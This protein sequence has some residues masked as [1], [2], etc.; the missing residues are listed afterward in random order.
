MLSVWAAVMALPF[1]PQ[2]INR[3][4]QSNNFPFLC[5]RGAEKE[6]GSVADTR[7]WIFVPGALFSMPGCP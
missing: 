4:F 5:H 2:A 6:P 7:L 3:L 1:H